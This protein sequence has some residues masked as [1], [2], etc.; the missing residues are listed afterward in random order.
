MLYT[1]A[2]RAILMVV[3]HKTS[4]LDAVLWQVRNMPAGLKRYYT[5]KLLDVISEIL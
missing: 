5:F 3:D 4:V 2:A 1:L